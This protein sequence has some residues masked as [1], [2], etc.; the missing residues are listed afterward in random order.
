DEPELELFLMDIDD[1]YETID[2][3]DNGD[4]I[5]A[6]L[7]KDLELYCRIIGGPLPTEDVMNDDEILA[8][9]HDTFDPAL[10]VTDSEDEVPPALPV[11]L[12]EAINALHVLV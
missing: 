4:P 7:I 8:M 3:T 9:V 2:L 6:N 5:A 10:A 12:S 11:S 1:E